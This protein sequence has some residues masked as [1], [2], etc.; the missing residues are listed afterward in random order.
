MEVGLCADG[1]G[2]GR[3]WCKVWSP[4]PHSHLVP[5]RQ[6]TSQPPTSMS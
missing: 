1:E 2:L 3:V 4:L 5:L 6:P